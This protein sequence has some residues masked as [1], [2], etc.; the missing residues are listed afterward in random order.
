MLRLETYNTDLGPTENPRTQ[1]NSPTVIGFG[2]E[3]WVGFGLYLPADWPVLPA[4]GWQVFSSVYGPPYAGTSSFAINQSGDSIRA[5]RNQN[6]GADTVWSMPLLRGVWMDFAWRFL[7]SED[8]AVGFYEGWLNTAGTWQQLTLGGQPRLYF[9]TL[10]ASHNG[11][12]NASQLTNYR[13]VDM[14]PDPHALFYAGH[15]VGRSLQA[16]DPHSHG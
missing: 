7:L 2:Q 13:M 15:R 3:Y 14:Y 16:V 10:D 9:R 8:P 11:G 4:G 1:V 12:P 6:Y 5:S